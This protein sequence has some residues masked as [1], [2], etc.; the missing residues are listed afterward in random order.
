M[1]VDDFR[2]DVASENAL[3]VAALRNPNAAKAVVRSI[4]PDEYLAEENQRVAE[5]IKR[6][7]DRGDVPAP[8][9]VARACVELG[10]G[11]GAARHVMDLAAYEGQIGELDAAVASVR[12]DA[13]RHQAWTETLP[14]LVEAVR[15]GKG[16]SDEVIGHARR[17][18][19]TFEGMGSGLVMRQRYVYRSYRDTIAARVAREIKVIGLGA[20]GFDDRLGSGFGPAGLTVLTGISGAGK[21]ALVTNMARMLATQDQ[22]PRLVLWEPRLHNAMD[23]IV[24]AT[25]SIA[26]KRIVRGELDEDEISRIDE[27]AAYWA[28]R[29]RFAGRLEHMRVV[30]GPG[31]KGRRRT[32]NLDVVDQIVTMAMSAPGTH[33]FFDLFQNGLPDR[34][35]DQI[36]STLS[37]LQDVV[38][39][40]ET[41]FFLIHQV[42]LKQ[43]E[44]TGKLTR[45]VVKGTGGWVESCDNMFAAERPHMGVWGA[46]DNK[47]WTHCW[48]LRDEKWGFTH[49]WTWEGEYQ[50]IS[51]P[52]LLEPE[53]G[54]KVD[55]A[56][57]QGGPRRAARAKPRARAK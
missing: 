54:E 46:D 26:H 4:R 8:N 40:L 52:V 2:V 48:K 32:T 13:R 31:T 30:S 7:V 56:D 45:A 51:D 10:Y 19:Q 23:S 44:G 22:H 6:C 28:E 12:W 9:R 38:A 3:L 57:I 39:D 25:T 16:G 34:R 41:H 29:I 20:Q 24:S 50:R 35:P 18:V 5:A 21:S 49:E 27:A 36:D 53:E 17:L 1:G 47:L 55:I 42:N 43:E 37:V 11:D 15:T 33:W 14:D